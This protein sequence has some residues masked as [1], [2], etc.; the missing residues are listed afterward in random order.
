MAPA[1][2]RLSDA[3][4]DL[5]VRASAGADRPAY[6]RRGEALAVLL[7]AAAGAP[8]DAR[9]GKWAGGELALI[10]RGG[11]P[12]PFAFVPPSAAAAWETYEARGLT[13]AGWA[14]EGRAFLAG[15]PSPRA[16]LRVE[17]WGVLL[18]EYDDHEEALV[19]REAQVRAPA[20]FAEA[21]SAG[22][23]VA[24]PPEAVG[25]AWCSALAP[26]PPTLLGASLAADVDAARTVEDLA[27]EALR[28][29]RPWH[30]RALADGAARPV[31][32]E[33]PA[34][35]TA[36]TFERAAAACK[37]LMDPHARCCEVDERVD[38]LTPGERGRTSWL[39]ELAWAAARWE[40]AADMGLRL[41]ATRAGPGGAVRAADNPFV[42]LLE[43]A[44]LGYRV[45]DTLGRSL[46]LVAPPLAI[47]P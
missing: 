45:G 41:R 37:A 39:R 3:L 27:E 38:R 16:V 46:L 11:L 28:R 6:P 23:L 29:A 9:L 22:D 43:V 32:C 26:V 34:W 42:P 7:G 12:T 24:L 17:A 10:P 33:G 40:A 20:D 8:S 14:D 31:W 47:G 35:R 25:G 19:T 18:G 15:W 5:L 4:E 36:G 21:P 30:G 1:D 13:P 2:D 44:A